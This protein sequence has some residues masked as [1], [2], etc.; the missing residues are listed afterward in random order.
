MEAKYIPHTHGLFAVTKYILEDRVVREHSLVHV[1]RNFD[2][3]LVRFQQWGR[4]FDMLAIFVG[5][6]RTRRKF[7]IKR[8]HA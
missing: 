4:R 5:E 1:L 6:L 2:P 3:E 8:I 7:L